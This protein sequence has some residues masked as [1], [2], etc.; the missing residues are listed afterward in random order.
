MVK[1]VRAFLGAMRPHPG[2]RGRNYGPL[3]GLVEA[4]LRVAY[5]GDW[6]ARLVQLHPGACAVR[7]VE[8][9]LPILPAG[10]APRRVGFVS[11][12]HVGPTTPA[13]LLDAAFAELA[14]ARLDV[15]LLGGDYVFLDATAEK[16][17]RLSALVASVPAAHKVAVLGNHDLWTDHG[18][19]ERALADV[20]VTV[21][22]DDA[23]DAG[24]LAIVGLDDPWTGTPDVARALSRCPGGAPQIV[25]C[26]APEGAPRVAASWPSSGAE[27][28]FVCGHTHGG[29]LATPFGPLVVHGEV[30]RRHPHGLHR[31]GPLHVFVSRGVGGIEV[32]FRAWAPPDVVVF[33]LETRRGGS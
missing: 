23:I 32:P 9:S 26:H 21:L 10:A 24:G 8:L 14:R 4:T 1:A 29:H 25:L 30:G 31:M 13:P 33:E 5:R 12:L 22:V 15:L 7:R 27:A 18:R 3:R 16:A 17:A 19:L 11:D 20:G 6:P 2:A 28:L